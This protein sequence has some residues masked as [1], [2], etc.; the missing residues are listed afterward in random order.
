[1]LKPD[2]IDSRDWLYSWSR[3]A[4]VPPVRILAERVG[5][6][7]DQGPTNSCT[8]NALVSI[9]EMIAPG[10]DYSRLFNYYLSRELFKGL[11]DGDNGSSPRHALRAAQKFGMALESVWPFDTSALNTRPSDAAFA[12]A[13]TRPIGGY[14]RISEIS[15]DR[16]R[17]TKHALASGYPV[18]YSFFVSQDF[19]RLRDD[20]IARSV[21][22]GGG[23]TGTMHA[24]A[25]IGYDQDSFYCENSWGTGW[26]N[27]GI[28]RLHPQVIARDSVDIWVV[29]GF[30]GMV[31]AAQSE[32]KYD[33]VRA[34][35]IKDY[36]VQRLG[37]IKGDA[38]TY[39]A[40]AEEI[41]AAMGW[42]PG[43]AMEILK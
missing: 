27:N 9:C 10:Q 30:N 35:V 23:A 16:I 25:L 43:T 28:G 12:D 26:G 19:I 5:A 1:M 31:G 20:D 34:Q 4:I 3:S 41:D 39:Q 37:L 18:H 38:Q 21:T 13:L 29:K 6:I 24:V 11:V 40:T 2:P 8:A 22:L 17:A 15:D 36:L 33:P 32:V 14:Y 7:E 42:N